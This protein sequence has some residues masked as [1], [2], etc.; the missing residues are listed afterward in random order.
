MWQNDGM[1]DKRRVNGTENDGRKRLGFSSKSLS[2]TA[3]E[4]PSVFARF[5]ISP[6]LTHLRCCCWPCKPCHRRCRCRRHRQVSL[7]RA[8]TTLSSVPETMCLIPPSFS[9][10]TMFSTDQNDCNLQI[11]L[12]AST[13][14][15]SH[16]LPI[17]TDNKRRK[18]YTILL[19]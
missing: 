13:S 12:I 1:F 7:T 18:F 6:S 8:S 10:S 3:R 5:R 15:P 4:R 17:C 16:Y 11:P 2:E 19:L 14:S 9:T